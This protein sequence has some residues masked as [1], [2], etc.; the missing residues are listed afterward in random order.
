MATLEVEKQH[1]DLLRTQLKQLA[2]IDAD[3]LHRVDQ[4]GQD[5]SFREGRPYFQRALRLFRDLGESNLD[6]LPTQ[7]LK[8]LANVAKKANEYFSKIQGFSVQA[9]PQNPAHAR[10]NLINTIRD[11]Y[12]D[13]FNQISP[14]IAYSVRKGTDFEQLEQKAR[15]R[16]SQVEQLVKELQK[17]GKDFAAE[18]EGIRDQVR[19]AAQ[20]VGVAQHAVHFKSEADQHKAAA[21]R[22]LKAV[23]W[24]AGITAL[25]TVV[26]VVFFWVHP[27]D[28]TTA[29]TIQLAIAKVVLFSLLFSAL[30]WTGRVYRSHQHNFVVNQ[31]RQ[32][33][34]ASFETFAKAATDEQTKSAVLLQATNCIFAPQASGYADS[35]AEAAGSPQI[36]EIIRNMT[37]PD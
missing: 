25:L 19:R 32:N 13:W 22:W 28:F 3:S 2:A 11:G 7:Q 5:L 16:V 21:G 15:E 8:A 6:P 4:L 18:T 10:D 29:E 12:D 37:G 26:N 27:I 9:H 34:L 1:R 24:I 33:A 14:I 30:V 20:E 36:M 35:S 17:Q 31:H 23:K